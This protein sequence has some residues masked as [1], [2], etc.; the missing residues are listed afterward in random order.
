[1][2]FTYTEDLT[3]DRD[4]VRFHTGDTDSASSFLS[5]A[6]ITSLLATQTSKQAA[7]IAGVRYIIT[8]L[9]TPNFHADWL[10][11]DNS[12]AIKGYQF[13][14]DQKKQEFGLGG[15]TAGVVHT[16][17]ED[18]AQTEEPDFTNGRPGAGG[19]NDN[20]GLEEFLF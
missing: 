17:R 9:S 20:S 16:Y 15:L 5:D 14:L 6:I 7:V 8:K 13:M 2:A 11:V 10:S 4:F 1:M 18:S 3:V 12:E 19:I